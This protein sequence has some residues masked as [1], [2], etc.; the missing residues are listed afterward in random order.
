MD[1]SSQVVAGQMIP[2]MQFD[3]YMKSGKAEHNM[4]V[5]PC[6]DSLL[7]LITSLKIKTSANQVCNVQK[8]CMKLPA[9]KEQ[10]YLKDL[11]KKDM[12]Q[13]P[14]N[15]HVP[16]LLSS[17][18]FTVL[19]SKGMP[20]IISEEE[21]GCVFVGQCL[22]SN[23]LV[24]I[25]LVTKR[26]CELVTLLQECAFQQKAHE[27]LGDQ[28]PGLI[29][30]LTLKRDSVLNQTCLKYLVV[31]ELCTIVPGV[32]ACMSLRDAVCR[33]KVS[34]KQGYCFIYNDLMLLFSFCKKPS[35]KRLPSKNSCLN[36]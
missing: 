8:D 9:H 12:F 30:L 11:V 23:D 18:F 31:S 32:P 5:E 6:K 26:T 36:E 14:L 34:I 27:V 19:M 1:N 33:I 16:Q 13:G 2:N 28:T 4:H 15:P 35:N 17:D 3:N 22:V 24:A 10:Q 7:Q 25:K 21:N 29:G 20:V